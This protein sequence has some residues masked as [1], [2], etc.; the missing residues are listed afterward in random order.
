[1][2][3]EIRM[4][5]ASESLANRCVPS[6]HPCQTLLWVPGQDRKQ[7]NATPLLT[8]ESGGQAVA[9]EPAGGLSEKASEPWEE[10]PKQRHSRCTGP[11][12]GETLVI[13]AE[14]WQGG[15]CG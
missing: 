14:K 8:F 10:H 2:D 12:A 1:M 9:I 13:L 15:G 5:P 6:T 3:L 4:A 11:G 7:N